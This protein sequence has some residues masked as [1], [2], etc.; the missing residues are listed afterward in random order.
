MEI[1][2]NYIFLTSEGHTYQPN[3]D[4][5]E[6]DIEN[7]QVIGISEGNNSQEAFKNLIKN[8]KHLLKT[9]FNEVFCYELSTNFRDSVDFFL[10]DCEQ[11]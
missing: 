8:R 2:K 5:D 11:K 7:L 1:M 9:T 4:S 10:L 6:P 3:L